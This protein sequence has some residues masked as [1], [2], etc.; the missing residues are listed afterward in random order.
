[1]TTPMDHFVSGKVPFLVSGYNQPPNH[2]ILLSGSFNPLHKGHEGLLRA[3]E[4]VTGR[5]GLLEL[6]VSN[7]DKPP[8]DTGEIQRRIISLEGR[9][10]IVLTRAPTFA[11]KAELFP[12]AWFAMGHDTAIRLLS[13]DYHADVPA[14]LARFRA[15]GTRFAVAGRLAGDRFLGL[16]SVAV[17]SGFEDLFI[18]IPERLFR[19]DISS[20]QLRGDLG[21]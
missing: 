12:G 13:P 21:S 6:S 8:L 15:L 14:M 3:A 5:K 17:P 7:V 9:F 19:E 10:G 20:T 4:Q 2:C 16:D 11:Q 1:M 18:P